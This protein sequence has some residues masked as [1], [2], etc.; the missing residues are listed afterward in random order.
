MRSFLIEK[1]TRTYKKDLHLELN[2]WMLDNLE[3]VPME[4]EGPVKEKEEN[5][6]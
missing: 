4:K 3:Y 1:A 5:W 2:A 6:T